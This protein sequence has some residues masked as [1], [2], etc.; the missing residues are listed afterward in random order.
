MTAGDFFGV[1]MA[2]GQ[3]T[4]LWP[5][6]RKRAPKQSLKLAGD[7]TLFRETLDR[8]GLFPPDRILV[9]TT[10]DQTEMLRRQAP[11]IPY[12]NFLVEPSP[13]GTAP[14]IGWAALEVRSRA[15]QG[16]MACLP[17]D[18]VIRNVARFHAL[19]GAAYQAAR[20]G[21]L[22]TLGI[23][24]T[25]PAAGYGYIEQGESLGQFEGIDGYRAVSFREKPSP[26]K[27]EE[28]VRQGDFLWN[29]GMF[30]WKANR[31]LEEIDGHMP[32]LGAGLR[33][34]EAQ[35]EGRARAAARDR[36]WPTLKRETLDYGIMERSA[37][38]AV[39]PAPDLGWLD[40]GNWERLF[41]V[42]QPDGDGNIVVGDRV[43]AVESA[44]SLVYQAGGAPRLVAV[45]GAEDLIVVDTGDTVLV[46]PRHRAEDVRRLVERLEQAGFGEFL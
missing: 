38:V 14:V 10:V 18:H 17:A 30:V 33:A 32:S 23:P 3:G 1:V 46:C 25:Y 45:F 22:V 15:P 5:F 9:A 29:S 6:S 19:L 7:R 43:A 36:V 44:R 27:A 24:P 13:M 26:Q 2:G 12:E 35:P 20:Q 8:I 4:R 28:Y 42:V 16:V 37:K 31:F 34:I 39:L 21:H 41:E 11:E 40:V